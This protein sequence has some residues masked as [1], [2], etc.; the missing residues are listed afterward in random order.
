METDEPE[1]GAAKVR[2]NFAG[3]HP[4]LPKPVRGRDQEVLP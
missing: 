3:A 1:R 4:R 2:S